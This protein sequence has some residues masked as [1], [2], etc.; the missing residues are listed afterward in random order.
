MSVKNVAT[1]WFYYALPTLC[2]NAHRTVTYTFIHI[3]RNRHNVKLHI[4]KF[5]SLDPNKD[6]DWLL[7]DVREQ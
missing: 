3:S 2:F 7:K 1:M 5:K 6:L 4:A